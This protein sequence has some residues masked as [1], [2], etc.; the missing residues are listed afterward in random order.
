LLI[1]DVVPNVQERVSWR[2]LGHVAVKHDL[3]GFVAEEK[4]LSL[5]M[6]SSE[7]ATSMLDEVKTTHRVSRATIHFMD[8]PL[9]RSCRLPRCR[10]RRCAK[11]ME[12]PGSPSATGPMMTFHSLDH[13]D[14]HHPALLFRGFWRR[15]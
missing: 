13:A 9:P 7:L 11:N 2:T 6:M 3:V 5:F 8:N 1:K 15:R 12:P 10:D 4:H 14:L